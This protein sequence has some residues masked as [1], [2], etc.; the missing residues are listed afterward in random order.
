[1]KTRTND[2][3]KCLGRSVPDTFS[4][5][6]AHL[7]GLKMRRITRGA[8]FDHLVGEREP[9]VRN[10]EAER[11]CGRQIDDE[12]E[13]SRLFNWQVRGFDTAQNFVDEFGSSAEKVGKVRSIGRQTAR[14]DVL[15]KTVHGR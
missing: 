15:S 14:L 13:L 9:P 3:S 2:E 12:I 6:S 11:L 8:S 7:T 5:R 1:M 4:A 10:L